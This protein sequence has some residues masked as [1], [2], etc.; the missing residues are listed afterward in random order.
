M[1]TSESAGVPQ[2]VST[3]RLPGW[4]EVESIRYRDGDHWAFVELTDTSDR[5]LLGIM[6][7]D[8]DIADEKVAQIRAVARAHGVRG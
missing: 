7:S 8:G 1:I 4:D 6:R 5:P 3:G 2:R